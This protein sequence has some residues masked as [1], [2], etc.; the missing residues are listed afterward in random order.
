[1][2]AP[3]GLPCGAESYVARGLSRD[4]RDAIPCRLVEL[5]SQLMG[6]S[7]QQLVIG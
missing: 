5:I 1:M 7:W 4:A 6:S 2:A 3:E